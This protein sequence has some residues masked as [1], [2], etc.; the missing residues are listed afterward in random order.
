MHTYKCLCAYTHT[1]LYIV[2]FR[3]SSD[4]KNLE[5]A[6]LI[7]K[8]KAEKNKK[9]KVSN[10]SWISQKFEFVGQNKILKSGDTH[11]SRE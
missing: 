5:V 7:L 1:H 11:K 10:F 9:L 2:L 4:I 6:T 8:Q 3:F